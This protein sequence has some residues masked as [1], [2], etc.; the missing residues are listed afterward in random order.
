MTL[1]PPKSTLFPY[2]TLFRSL[3]ILASCQTLVRCP[4]GAGAVSPTPPDGCESDRASVA[5]LVRDLEAREWFAEFRPRPTARPVP[6]A[7]ESAGTFGRVAYRLVQSA[8]PHSA[9]RRTSPPSRAIPNQG[10]RFA[11][12]PESRR[13]CELEWVPSRC[14][15]VPRRHSRALQGKVFSP[16]CGEL[17]IAPGAEAAANPK[18]RR[19]GPRH[20]TKTLP[21]SFVETT[22]RDPALQIREARPRKNGDQRQRKIFPASG[23][24][25]PRRTGSAARSR[26]FGNLDRGEDLGDYPVGI[27]PFQIGLRL[28]Q[29]TVAQHRQSS[30]LDVV[31]N[32]EIAAFDAG[33]GSRHVKK[34]N[35]GPRAGPQ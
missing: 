25:Q 14:F 21:L 13:R 22:M 7:I 10:V 32:E 8:S 6:A 11:F 2:T 33:Q 24:A 35:R 1:R 27:Q 23:H 3:D 9:P 20:P 31:G 30:G 19:Q 15:G 29:H 16:K 5:W 26:S 18:A 12:E 4:A 17:P 28:Q 34:A